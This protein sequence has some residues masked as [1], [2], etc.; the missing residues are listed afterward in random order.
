LGL[1]VLLK[2][3]AKNFCSDAVRDEA[4]DLLPHAGHAAQRASAY[5]PKVV[6]GPLAHP[7]RIE[8]LGSDMRA[9]AGLVSGYVLADF[10]QDGAQQR[11]RFAIE[12]GIPPV[13]RKRENVRQ[14][15]AFLL[16]RKLSGG[17]NSAA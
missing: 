9:G 11:G 14:R 6:H 5:S 8:E 7:R 10:V 2:Q 12:H 1:T 13:G 15:D 3:I 17:G 16:L 4:G